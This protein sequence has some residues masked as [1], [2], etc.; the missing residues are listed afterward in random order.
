[1]KILWL[2]PVLNH[3][4]S[5]FL[6]HLAESI[7]ITVLKGSERKMS[8][9][10]EL[11]NDWNFDII[12]INVP[13]S[14]FGFSS[15]VRKTLKKNFKNYNW[16]LIPAEKKNLLLLIYAIYLRRFNKGT[17]LISYN[18]LFIKPHKGDVKYIDKLITKFFYRNLDRVIFYTEQSYKIAGVV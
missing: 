11:V 9:D 17:K 5:R 10:K 8:G 3:Y 4:K 18:H 6:N 1:M 14:K 7:D 15:T 16:I 13:K 2:S 12:K